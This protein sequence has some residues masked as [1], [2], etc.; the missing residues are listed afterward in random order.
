MSKFKKGQSGNPS[1]RPKQESARIREKL[2]QHSDE[3]V[4]I[5]LEKIKDGDTAALKM[6]LD[7][8]SPSL[9]P[10]SA[11]IKIESIGESLTDK[12]N[13]VFKSTIGGE[14]SPDIASQLITALS[15]VAKIQEIS[16]LEER[17]AA[18][19]NQTNEK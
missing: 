19:E 5:L 7:R 17:I 15:G 12:A 8:L 1:G 13:A 9:K 6:A 4:N 16:E 11:P 18:L 2:N 14:V 3:I 10:V